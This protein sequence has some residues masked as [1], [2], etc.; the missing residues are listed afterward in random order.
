MRLVLSHY[1]A[2]WLQ[3]LY[4]SMKAVFNMKVEDVQSNIEQ[5]IIKAAPGNMHK[6]TLELLN[7]S[8]PRF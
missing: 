6:P 7:E 5:V 8:I 2:G 1:G 4:C 3:L